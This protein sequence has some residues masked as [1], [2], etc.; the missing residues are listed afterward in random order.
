MALYRWYPIH[1]FAIT[2]ELDLP[3]G[4]LA[5]EKIQQLQA[6]TISHLRKHLI[7]LVPSYTSLTLYFKKK[8]SWKFYTKEIES[9]LVLAEHNKSVPLKKEREI[10]KIPVCYELDFASDLES[11]ATQLNLSTIQIIE[12]HHQQLYQVYAIGFTPGFPYMGKIN[13]Q[14]VVPRK[15]IPTPYIH[16]GSVAIAHHQTGIYPFSTPGGW[17]VIGRTP[18]SLF[19]KNRSP[20]CFL[21]T[22]DQVRF[23]PI[24]KTEFENWHESSLS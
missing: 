15:E 24:S 21:E 5:H 10:K 12:L 2:I 17:H 22:G 8:H 3:M 7:D 14:L 13:K 9:I 18:L 19:D 4:P 11:L 6:V 20:V 23:I 16:A 1:D